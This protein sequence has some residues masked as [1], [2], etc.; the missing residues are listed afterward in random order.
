MLSR[1]PWTT[2]L[3]AFAPAIVGLRRRSIAG[4][5]AGGIVGS[6]GFV[7]AYHGAPWGFILWLAAWIL[8]AWVSARTSTGNE[9][10]A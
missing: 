2:P 1:A 4:S 6:A 7:A 10:L 5:L 9:R 8:A 3:I